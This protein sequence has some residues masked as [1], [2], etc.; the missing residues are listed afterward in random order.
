MTGDE[1]KQ[2]LL[3]LR[4]TVVPLVCYFLVD[5]R[6][7]RSRTM[8]RGLVLLNLAVN[9]FHLPARKNMRM[10]EFLGNSMIYGGLL[11]VLIP[12]NVYVPAQHRESTLPTRLLRASAAV[13]LLLAIVMPIWT[14]SRS[15]SLLCVAVFVGSACLLVRSRKVLATLGAV[16]LVAG[17][18]HG[19]VW[20]TNYG[21]A[22]FGIYR[23]VPAPA[24]TGG[25][26]DARDK[27][28]EVIDE[29]K[30]KAD[31]NRVAL[32]EAS[33]DEIREDPVFTD[34]RLYFPY[35]NDMGEETATA[36][37]FVPE[38]LNAYGG[39]GFVLYLSL[40]GVALVP[41]WRRFRMR[42]IGA[43]E[44]VAAFLTVGAALGCSMG[45]PTMLILTIVV[46]LWLVVGA[47]KQE[48]VIAM[49]AESAVRDG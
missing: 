35:D 36:H 16:V 6:L 41:G 48:Q 37:N 17:V 33:I 5:A 42:R 19:V 28:I 27:A 4:T 12:L 11:V 32:A 29:E 18:V 8:V 38:H 15:L 20:K 13:N 43:R 31:F 45:Q 22:A 24:F 10:S 7:D 46:P 40:F 23:I 39:L 25:V 47:L 44:N 3:A 9:V 49:E 14:G 30:G 2:S 34:G 26:G 21:G 1:V